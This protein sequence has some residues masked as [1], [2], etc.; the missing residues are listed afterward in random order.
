MM[1]L[2]TTMIKAPLATGFKEISWAISSSKPLNLS[3]NTNY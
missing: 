3:K 2:V 1:R